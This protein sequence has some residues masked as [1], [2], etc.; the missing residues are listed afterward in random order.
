LV[1]RLDALQQVIAAQ[2]HHA[3]GGVGRDAEID[4]RQP[5]PLVSPE[6]PARTGRSRPVP[7]QG[8]LK[9]GR[10]GV[11]RGQAQA[12]GDRVAQD[13]D[14]RRLLGRRGGRAGT[15]GQGSPRM[16]PRSIKRDA[17][18]LMSF[19]CRVAVIQN[20]NAGPSGSFMTDDNRPPLL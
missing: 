13:R 10:H 19:L 18:K 14:D 15:E 5:P 20:N 3:H 9:L 11:A 16:R 1:T 12:R 17:V 4:P 6:T 2:G 8:R 7:L